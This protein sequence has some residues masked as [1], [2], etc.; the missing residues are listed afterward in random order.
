MALPSGS[1]GAKPSADSGYGIRNYGVGMAIG[2]DWLAPALP[3]ST[4]TAVI[5]ALNSWVDWYDTSGFSRDQPIGNYFVGYFLAKT[6]TAIATDTDNAK[7]AAYWTDVQTHLWGQLVKPAYSAWM[8]GGGW[9]EG[10]G[11]GP[12]AVRGVAE[13][14]WGVE[15][16]K[17]LSW[18]SDLPQA[19]DQALYLEQ[20]A[21]PSL[22]RM[23]DR[24]TVRSGIA[25]KP[26]AA[27]MSSLATILAEHGDANAPTAMAFTDDIVATVGDD[28]DP[29]QTFLYSDPARARTS[30]ASLPLSYNAT[31]PG[32]VAMR[33]SWDKTASWASLTAG[34]Y[35]NAPDSGEQLFDAGGVTMVAGG[36]PV[37]VNAT[38]WI[39]NTGGTAG[40][41]YVYTDSWG[42]G[43]RRLYN[44]FFVTDPGSSNSPGQNS[45][46]PNSSNAHVER[47]E[48]GGSYVRARAAGLGDQYGS[49]SSH[50][51]T[52]YTRDVVYMRPGTLVLFD[53]TTIASASA[54]RWM[55]F[56][57]PS[58][59]K[60]VP[61]ADATQHR[62]DVTSGG[63]IRGSLRLLLPESPAIQTVSLPG[64]TTRIEVHG[65]GAASEQWLSVVTAS[66]TAPDQVR[67]SAGDGNVPSNNAVGVEVRGSREQVVL[68]PANQAETALLSS[69]QYVVNQ[70]ANADHVIVDMKPSASGYAI[71]AQATGSGLSISVST[72]G[73]FQASPAGVL[74]FQ[75]TKTG[76]VSPGSPIPPPAGGSGGTTGTGTG[77]TSGSGAA[78]AP[79]AGGSGAAGA[80]GNGG[81]G[82]AGAPG[83]GGSG[84]AGAPGAGGSGAASA[85]GTGG[86]GAAGAPGA[87]GSGAASAP[88]AGGSG[89]RR[90]WRWRK[91]RGGRTWRRRQWRDRWTRLDRWRSGKR[92]LER[93]IGKR[94][95]GCERK[96]GPVHRPGTVP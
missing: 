10:W 22:K 5:T 39:P 53:R 2:Y 87:G 42:G 6:Y 81:S 44:S 51:V 9:P 80:P 74:S 34:R 31:G 12:R 61:L 72:G 64:G 21:W 59:P 86:S 76:T 45:K 11:Y 26:S 92:R 90:T 94:G 68:F 8:Q 30:Y 66:A 93:Q 18:Y 29:W 63:A 14:L 70:S 50:P 35:I 27:L 47:F 67:L 40:E 69:V 36:D 48:D 32:D 20:F 82:A 77:G 41:D 83:T 13:V 7:A 3:A 79:G 4:K 56:H 75:V 65:P 91:R 84:A 23:A 78:G 15:T 43:G 57:V 54:N 33:S 88:G 49:G 37:L 17:G 28:R 24:G 89:A 25:L 52:A 16:G 96:L 19:R 58:A 62:Y 85:P 55:A 71:S 95:G 1:G 46:S 73:S 60:E 38:G